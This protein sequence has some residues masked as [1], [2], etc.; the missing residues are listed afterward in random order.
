MKTEF[1]RIERQQAEL[2]LNESELRYR[3]LL[4]ATTDYIYTVKVDGGHPSATVHGPGCQAVTGYSSADFT[5]DPYL[6]YR[7]IHEDDRAAVV[8][9]AEFILRGGT[10]PPLEHRINHKLGGVRWIRNTTIPHLDT[11]GRLTAYDGLI[12]DITSRKRAELLLVAQY[13]VARELSEGGS[14]DETTPKV[15]AQ[16]CQKLL[17]HHA[18]YWHCEGNRLVRESGVWRAP[19]READFEPALV[20]A[21]QSMNEGLAG[22]AAQSGEAVWRADISADPSLTRTYPPAQAGLRCGCAFLIRMDHAIA[23]VV[24]IYSREPQEIDERMLGTL[25]T[26]GVHLGQ[27]LEQKNSEAKLE[28]ERNLLRT[29]VDN[30]PVCIYVKDTESHFVLSNPAHLRLLGAATEQEVLGKTDHDFFPRE[31]AERSQSDEQILIRTGKSLHDSEE[32]LLDRAGRDYWFLTT[33]VPLKNAAGQITGLVGIGRDITR[34]KLEAQALKRANA[35]LAQRG[36]ILKT[37]LRKLKTSHKELERTQL[38]LIQAAKMESV[39]TL[40]AGVAHE[41]KNPLQTI[42]MGLDY[43]ANRMAQPDP[44]LGLVLTDMREAVRR[45]NTIIRE[46]LSLSANTEFHWIMTDLNSLLERS[47]RLTKSTLFTNHIAVQLGLAP[48][49]PLL[50]VDPPK[51]EQVFLNVLINSIQAMPRGGTLTVRTRLLVMNEGTRQQTLLCKFGDGEKL[52]VVEVSDTGCGLTEE[53]MRRVFDPFFTTK[54]VGVGTGLGLSV[55]RKIIELHGGA[56]EIKN[57]PDGPGAIVTVVLK[58]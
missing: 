27:F 36:E 28:A 58:T 23:G 47:L 11:K 3:R 5:A 39:G 10:P 13:A 1:I 55:A 22:C 49:L 9:Q 30:L 46:L 21:T 25:G 16:L 18:A 6:W 57:A 33:K 32:L 45:A 40:A 24:E 51:L 17:W 15:L 26:L 37:M 12:S 38:Q 41:V 53:A 48:D 8:A 54:P 52:V 50:P 43:L 34:R 4:S 44:E 14:W 56:I 31:L 19:L 2:A 35:R 7:V 29:M 20:G 42:L